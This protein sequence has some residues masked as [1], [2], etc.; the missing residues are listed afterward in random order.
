MA[1]LSPAYPVGA[2]SYSSGIEWAVE[3][4]DV[5]KAETLKDW[6]ATMLTD[7]GGF[8]DAVLFVHAHRAVD[9]DNALR[10]I[11]EL[12]AALAPSK[13][14]H[15]ETTAQGNAFTEA[16]RAAWPCAA[17]DRLKAAW[18]GP[19]AYPVAVAVAAAGN[20]IAIQSALAA[21]LQALVANWVS[22]GVRLVPL[23]QTDGQRVIAA[24]E[25]VVAATAR[26]ALETSLDDLGA[27]TFRADLASLRH[28]TQYTRLFRS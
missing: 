7:G 23:G 18:D 12:A 10:G 25:P 5:T 24:L 17:L 14:R 27:S 4:G 22:A 28:E 1:W 3:S 20:G 15:L 9:D 2:F 16:T 11:A 26:R 21:F 19:V 13:E 8:C 6:L